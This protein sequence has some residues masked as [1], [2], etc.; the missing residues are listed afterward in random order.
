MTYDMTPS[1]ALEWLTERKLQAAAAPHY[2]QFF[3][4][5]EQLTRKKLTRDCGCDYS[6][7]YYDCIRILTVYQQKGGNMAAKAESKIKVKGVVH[8]RVNGVLVP[9]VNGTFTDAEAIKIYEHEGPS[10][11]EDIAAIEELVS[12]GGK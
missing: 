7:A 4:L 3:H 6:A 8:A 10:V 9:F 5:V 1:A 2:P 12:K 11:F